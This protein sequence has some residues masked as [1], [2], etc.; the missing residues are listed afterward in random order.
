MS[1]VI[2]ECIFPVPLFYI[3][4]GN[5]TLLQYS[6]LENPMDEGAWWAAVH[7]AA[8]GRTRLRDFTFTYI[9]NSIRRTTDK[10]GAL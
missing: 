2:H 7:G 3:G 8:E 4:K 5:D 6:C 9:C 1:R 10:E